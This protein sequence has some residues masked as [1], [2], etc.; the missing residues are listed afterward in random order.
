MT[1]ALCPQKETTTDLN[2][3][4]FKSAFNLFFYGH[5][6]MTRPEMSLPAGELSVKVAIF[7]QFGQESSWQIGN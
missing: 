7:G 2:N 6:K 1:M 4:Y 5:F 3:R